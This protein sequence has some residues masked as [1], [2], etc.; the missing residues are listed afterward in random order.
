[1]FGSTPYAAT[2]FLALMISALMER[3]ASYCPQECMKRTRIG[4][5]GCADDFSL[6]VDVQRRV[7]ER[8]QYLV[9]AKH[10]LARATD[11]SPL[12]L[13]ATGTQEIY[14]LDWHEAQ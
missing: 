12:V 2:S 8:S 5:S 10:L 1:V 14:A 13:H 7:A 3:V 9:Y 11:D 4:K 6:I